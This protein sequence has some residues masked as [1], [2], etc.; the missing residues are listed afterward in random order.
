M[1]LVICFTK[2][3]GENREQARLIGIDTEKER[4]REKD[5]EW[6]NDQTYRHVAEHLF[7]TTPVVYIRYFLSH[8][9]F[10]CGTSLLLLFA[11]ALF[12]TFAYVHNVS[13]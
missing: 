11:S 9:S 13:T 12:I 8:S 5:R 1:R 6:Q 4:E 3:H 10:S 7:A 2:R